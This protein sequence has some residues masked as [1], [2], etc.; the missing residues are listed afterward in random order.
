MV[1]Q[2]KY[3]GKWRT[4][5]GEKEARKIKAWRLLNK[6]KT[7]V[8]AKGNYPKILKRE[9]QIVWFKNFSSSPH[10][11]VRKHLRKGRIV[12]KHKRKIKPKN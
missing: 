6:N 7:R 5:H 3:K 4:Y 8:L 12:R 1:M 11:I 10:T 2:Y 9:R